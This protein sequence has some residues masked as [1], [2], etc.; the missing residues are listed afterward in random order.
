MNPPSADNNTTVIEMEKNRI[1]MTAFQ[2]VI[3]PTISAAM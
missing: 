2:I 1:I 3:S